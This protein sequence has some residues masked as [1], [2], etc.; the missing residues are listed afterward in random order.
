MKK[1]V[2]PGLL[3]LEEIT[4]PAPIPQLLCS[5][6]RAAAGRRRAGPVSWGAGRGAEPWH[7][8]E[9]GLTATEAEALGLETPGAPGQGAAHGA[10]TGGSGPRLVGLRCP[11]GRGLHSLGCMF[12]CLTALTAK[13]QSKIALHSPSLVRSEALASPGL[14]HRFGSASSG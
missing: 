14:T 8:Q 5:W 11:Q 6:H 12:P 4:V 2:T 3:D 13:Q 10:G 7:S 9:Q 1:S